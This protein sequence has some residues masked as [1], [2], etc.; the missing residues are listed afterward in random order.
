[1]VSLN[2]DVGNW[3]DDEWAYATDVAATLN[4]MLDYLPHWW[5]KKARASP[6]SN[7]YEILNSYAQEFGL[8]SDELANMKNEVFVDTSTGTYLDALA[9]LYLLVRRANESDPAFRGRIKAFRTTFTGGGT[10]KAIESSI[11]DE[12]AGTIAVVTDTPGS[13]WCK[14]TITISSSD[15]VGKIEGQEASY[16]S[17]INN[18]KAA[19]IDLSTTIMLVNPIFNEI[20]YLGEYVAIGTNTSVFDTQTQTEDLRF[21]AEL[22]LERSGDLIWDIDNWDDNYWESGI[23]EHLETIKILAQQRFNESTTRAE[24]ISYSAGA[25]IIE[26]SSKTE[27][28]HYD[29]GTKPFETYSP[30]ETIKFGVGLSLAIESM[31]RTEVIEQTIFL[32]IPSPITMIWDTDNWDDSIWSQE[33]DFDRTEIVTYEVQV[34]QIETQSQAENIDLA[35]NLIWDGIG[36]EGDWNSGNWSA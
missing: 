20:N 36:Q 7:T 9:K 27:D 19:G 8:Y 1:M 34:K 5:N 30:G 4:T 23:M 16:Y 6:G 17:L 31:T 29:L 21:S 22:N 33:E 11:Y 18:V 25:S 14:A 32:N 35:Y 15:W 3:D 13:S 10:K 26:T 12:F 24:F 28:I 2:W